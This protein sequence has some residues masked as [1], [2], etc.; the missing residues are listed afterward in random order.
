MGPGVSL[1]ADSRSTSS[2]AFALARGNRTERNV[3]PLVI[4]VPYDAPQGGDPGRHPARTVRADLGQPAT[5]GPLDLGGPG[6]DA[7]PPPRSA[8]HRCGVRVGFAAGSAARLRAGTP[9]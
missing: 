7:Q 6:P 9:G 2:D 3:G 4:A 1:R 5:G 8:Q